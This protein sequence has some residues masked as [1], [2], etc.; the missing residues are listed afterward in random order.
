MC[1]KC[2]I[3]I[4]YQSEIINILMSVIDY[5]KCFKTV[6]EERKEY[7]KLFCFIFREQF[8]RNEGENFPGKRVGGIQKRCVQGV[9]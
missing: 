2:I 1:A 5:V 9:S 7:K 4:I 6:A 8:M 3:N